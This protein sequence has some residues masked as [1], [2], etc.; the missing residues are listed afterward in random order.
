M[1]PG[2]SRNRKENLKGG[3]T[4]MKW[5]GMMLML[6]TSAASD[7]QNVQVGQYRVGLMITRQPESEWTHFMKRVGLDLR[8]RED[9]GARF[10]FL[11]QRS[12]R[13]YREVALMTYGVRGRTFVNAGVIDLRYRAYAVEFV[14]LFAPWTTKEPAWFAL[15]VGGGGALVTGRIQ[16]EELVLND[17]LFTGILSV[18]IRCGYW[19]MGYRV[20]RF[21]ID[22]MDFELGGIFT[23]LAFTM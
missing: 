3:A 19:E 17:S 15:Y 14:H 5:I 21:T 6:C 18:G 22:E 8:K 9:V 23:V 12:H 7:S 2:N 4:T 16:I 13:T 10:S 11:R 1:K 20:T